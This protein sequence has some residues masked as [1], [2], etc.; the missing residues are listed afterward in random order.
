MYHVDS[1]RSERLSWLHDPTAWGVADDSGEIEGAGG[2]YDISPDGTELS[3]TAPAFKDFWSRTYYSPLLIKHDASALVGDIPADMEAT[4]CV[5]F[6]FNPMN[7]FD[8]A[9]IA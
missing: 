3:M 5:D 7:Q 8:Q 6:D 9:V 1:F 4:V 2:S